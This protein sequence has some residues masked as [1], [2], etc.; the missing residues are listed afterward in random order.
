MFASSPFANGTPRPAARLYRQVAVE[1]QLAGDADAHRLVAMLFDGLFEAIAQARGAMRSGDVA[2]KCDALRR[3]SAIVEEGLRAALDLR[4]GGSLAQD[5]SD[6]YRY[7]SLRLT[8]ANLRSDE[9]QLDEVCRLMQPLRE[10]WA[11]IA[12]AARAA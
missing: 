8:T 5:L 11:S 7:V 9:G 3:A 10:A 6:L 4:G 2:T 1:S 12:P